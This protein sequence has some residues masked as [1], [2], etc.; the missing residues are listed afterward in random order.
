MYSKFKA[1]NLRRNEWLDGAILIDSVSGRMIERMVK[2]TSTGGLVT[3]TSPDIEIIEST[4]VFDKN[5][6]MIYRGDILQ[7]C[8]EKGKP[9]G[10][11]RGPVEF[12]N[13]KYSVPIR[14]GKN[15]LDMAIGTPSFRMKHI[16][17]GNVFENPELLLAKK[18]VPPT[19]AK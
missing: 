12:R 10:A 4:G 6:M 17:V 9:A 13:G 11:I 5:G 8:S 15:P 7:Y 19:K 18:N 14:A 16:V 1:Y 3:H 2:E